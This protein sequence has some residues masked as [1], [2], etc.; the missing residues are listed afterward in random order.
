[1]YLS[2]F[3]VV[4]VMSIVKDIMTWHVVVI[5]VDHSIFDAAQLMTSHHV[6][7]LVIMDGEI[8]VGIVTERDFVRRVAAEK[9]SL[10]TRVSEV[11]SK[12]VVTVDAD[13]SIKE[14]ATLMASNKIRRLPVLKGNKLV[15][16][17]VAADIVRN[18][19]K[20]TVSEQLLSA[21]GRSNLLP[22]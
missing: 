8:L 11:M 22:S 20:K 1:M 18:L 6:G 14:A 13:A 19:G 12:S 5:G 17:I 16:I 21:L 4:A 9:L 3:F 7:C 10:N 2:Y 15:G